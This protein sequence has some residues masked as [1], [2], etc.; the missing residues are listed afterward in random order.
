MIR[1]FFLGLSLGLLLSIL[2]LQPAYL[3][4]ETRILPEFSLIKT[5]TGIQL[6]RNP[7]G[8]FIQVID[9]HQGAS[10]ELLLG[11]QV[12]EGES[13][14]YGGQNPLLKP[15]TLEQFWLEL[16]Q[17]YGE[18]SFSVC[19]GQFFNLKNPSELAFP[20][21]VNG[22][23]IT[24]GYAGNREFPGEKVVLGISEN[25]VDILPVSEDSNFEKDSFP[26]DNA[27]V[28][29]RE[30]GGTKSTEWYSKDPFKER[31]RT[32]IGVADFHL[33]FI[34]T[35]P[36]KTQGN[37]AQLLKEFG[38]KKVMMLDGGGSTQLIV[39]GTELLSSSDITSRTIPQA[40]GVLSGKKGRSL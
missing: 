35:S 27:I 30:D 7:K 11:E 28:G 34:L 2:L 9:L 25:T 23:L 3:S 17:Y 10:V 26:F 16:S 19:N 36:V 5:K 37:A 29:I 8:D 38:A 14:A 15:Q 31:P 1:K 39:E 21:Q 32:F 20:V 22:K 18:R 13:A 4:G 24:T 40:I 12:G 6:Y 33:I